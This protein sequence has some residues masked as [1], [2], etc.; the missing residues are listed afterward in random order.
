VATREAADAWAAAGILGSPALLAV[1]LLEGA[2]RYLTLPKGYYGLDSLLMPLAFMALARVV[3]S[4]KNRNIWRRRG[5]T[6]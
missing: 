5:P 4:Y 6:A 3:R 1:G 2:K